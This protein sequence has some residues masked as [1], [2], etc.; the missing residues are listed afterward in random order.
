MLQFFISALRAVV[1]MLGLCLLAQGVLH[2]LAGSRRL[3]NPL[4]Q[5]FALISRGPQNLVARFLPAAGRTSI[6]I[7]TFILLFFLWLGLAFLRKF[8]DQSA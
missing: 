2:V 4:Y 8:I 3:S 1:E 5:L 7:L 6:G